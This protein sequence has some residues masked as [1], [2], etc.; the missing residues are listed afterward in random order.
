MKRNKDNKEK[1]IDTANI[2]FY[3]NGYNQTSISDVANMIGISKGNMTYHFHSKN[4]LLYAVIDKRIIQIEK[5]LQEWDKKYLEPNDRL[6]RF[7]RMLLKE[8]DSLIQFGCPVGSLN[9]EL[10]KNQRKLQESSLQMLELFR[11]WLVNTF[12]KMNHS[13]CY[14]KSNHLLSMAQGA[15]LMAY[16]YSDKDLLESECKYMFEWIDRITINRLD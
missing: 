8:S 5:N 15:A 6:K 10:G 16:V 3:K 2:M 14:R 13:D 1:I 11:N 7:V 12:K 9:V 4:D